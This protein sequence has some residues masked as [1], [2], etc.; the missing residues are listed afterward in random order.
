MGPGQRARDYPAG[1]GARDSRR[2]VRRSAAAQRTAAGELLCS[3]PGQPPA[4]P[5]PG[6]ARAL[7]PVASGE[8][9]LRAAHQGLNKATRQ[10]PCSLS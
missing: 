10:H 7:L 2:M 9:A 4:Q 8:L 5:G 3:D 1:S 6:R